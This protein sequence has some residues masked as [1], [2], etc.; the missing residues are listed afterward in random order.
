VNKRDSNTRMAKPRQG[1]SGIDVGV[2]GAAILLRKKT[3]GMTKPY[4]KR[5]SKCTLMEQA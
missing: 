4:A 5:R 3:K 1:V 2:V